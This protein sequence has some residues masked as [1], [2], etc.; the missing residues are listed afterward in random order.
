MQVEAK[1]GQQTP[2][3][4]M[5]L[6]AAVWT[7]LEDES[8][9]AELVR[10]ANRWRMSHGK[11]RPRVTSA[12]LPEARLRFEGGQVDATFSSTHWQQQEQL[13]VEL[14]SGDTRA[15]LIHKLRHAA[16]KA[17]GKAARQR[18][19]LDFIAE[20]TV[21]EAVQQDA[22]Q[23]WQVERG[24][25]GWIALVRITILMQFPHPEAEGSE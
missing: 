10:P 8:S 18:L 5:Q 15:G 4:W 16:I 14:A 12:D 7:A 1:M 23:R 13:V 2:D 17:I 24:I 22:P 6:E 20:V 25:K 9:F 11:P 19:G 21:T 3:P